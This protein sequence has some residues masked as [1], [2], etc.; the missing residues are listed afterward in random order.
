MANIVAT[1]WSPLVSV[2]TVALTWWLSQSPNRKPWI[3]VLMTMILLLFVFIMIGD[4]NSCMDKN[5]NAIVNIYGS[6]TSFLAGLTLA[7]ALASVY[8]VNTPSSVLISNPILK[9]ST[10]LISLVLL[11]LSIILLSITSEDPTSTKCKR[12]ATTSFLLVSEIIIN[13]ILIGVA[14]RSVNFSFNRRRPG[15]FFKTQP[16]SPVVPT[17]ASP[18]PTPPTPFSAD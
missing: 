6:I 13:A 11:I 1:V 2:I 12:S 16:P 4:L 8:T 5:V 7:G 10:I 3:P 17:P 18:T 9:I 15:L 14:M